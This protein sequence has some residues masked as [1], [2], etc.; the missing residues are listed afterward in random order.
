MNYMVEQN[1]PNSLYYTLKF[2]AFY[3]IQILLLNTWT[4][5]LNKKVDEYALYHEDNKCIPIRWWENICQ[6]AVQMSTS[7]LEKIFS[8]Q[9][10]HG[11]KEHYFSI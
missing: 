2:C 7:S 6:D 10:T 8:D 1:Y 4:Q 9:T 5:K 3:C 11:V